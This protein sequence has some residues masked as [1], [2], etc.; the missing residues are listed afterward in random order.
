MARICTRAIAVALSLYALY[1]VVG[2]VEPFFYRTTFLLLAL[3][4]VFLAPAL[5]AGEGAE[6]VQERNRAGPVEWALAAATVVTLALPL[7]GI[8]EFV[9]RAATPTILD[10]IAGAIVIGLVLEA[11]RRTAG[12]VLP[13]TALL[14]LGYAYFGPLLDLAG[15]DLLAHR[16]Y[17]LDRLIATQWMTLEGI[18]GVPLDVASTYLILFTIFGAVLDRTGAGRFFVDWALAAMGRAG[19]R[20]GA[21]RAVVAAGFLLGMVSG[22]GV[23]TTVTLASCSWPM[24][25][26][27]GADRETGAA[28]FA[29]SGIG[30][31]LAPPALGAAA[32]LIA[33]FV[34]IPYRQVVVMA[35]VPAALYYISVI[36]MIEG[37]ARRAGLT[38]SLP[39]LQ[40]VG[41]LT[42]RWGH[43]FVAPVLMI[44]LLAIG[45]SAFRAVA[46]ATVVALA[47][48]WLRAESR[49][50]PRGILDALAQGGMAILP[51]IATTATAG[52]IVGVVT[53]TG[54]GLNLAGI[55]ET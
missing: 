13:A 21:G 51:I 2:V 17:P 18:F 49:L 10:T 11:T 16:G 50:G 52:I 45:I 30:A 48:G 9:A 5:P 28:I 3:V 32:F 47:A 40:P 34:G 37:D 7:A 26:R 14:F 1:W 42:R 36:L 43:F 53:L 4:L 22:S 35:I 20:S 12:T 44:V 46:I 25:E 33:E 19:G 27:A 31:I 39:V 23:A 8:A 15:L 24:L 38:G 54:L 41:D 6:I 55:I 29:A